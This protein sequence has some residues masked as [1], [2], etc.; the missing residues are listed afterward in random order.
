MLLFGTLD[1]KMG[2]AHVRT[3]PGDKI[4]LMPGSSVPVV[5]RE[6]SASEFKLVGDAWVHGIMGREALRKLKYSE[7]EDP[8][9]WE[10]LVIK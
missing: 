8:A 9:N 5:L 6:I 3:C 2:W 1:G 7:M 4:F 10:Q